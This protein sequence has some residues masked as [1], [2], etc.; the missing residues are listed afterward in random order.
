M[1]QN[2]SMQDNE[3]TPYKQTLHTSNW[4]LYYPHQRYNRC[5][6][7][8]C[9]NRATSAEDWGARESWPSSIRVKRTKG[10]YQLVALLGYQ[11]SVYVA[12]PEIARAA[13][14]IAVV[15]R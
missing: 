13:I 5:A 9:R 11:P 3:R 12:D 8:F 2:T 15:D 4:P 6:V 10:R 14:V 7:D 1:I